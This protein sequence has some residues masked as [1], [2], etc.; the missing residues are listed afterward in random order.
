MI[1]EE[2]GVMVASHQSWVDFGIEK[3]AYDLRW[4]TEPGWVTMEVEAPTLCMVPMEIGG[5]CE[6]RALPDQ[7]VEGEYFGPGALTFAASASR[8]AIH[9]AEI[10]QARLC[11]FV[12]HVS[13]AG[14]LP[15]EATAAIHTLQTRYMFRDERIRTCAGLL[16]SDHVRAGSSMAFAHSL[17]K[18]LY[19]A[20]IEMGKERR[21]PSKI[22]ALPGPIWSTISRYVRDHLDEPIT[23]E[24]LAGLAEMPAGRF[25]EAFREMTGMSLRQW[26]MDHRV[27]S[28]QRL[29]MDNPNESLAEIASLCGFA[30]QSHFSRA[31]LKVIGLTPTA[32]LHSR[33]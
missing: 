31:F 13:D 25:S 20:L 6:L 11:C 1:L 17:S 3:V 9:A 26:H 22:A 10:R 18:A 15:P 2:R 8:V 32:W 30:D 4:L 14:Y 28:A 24:I 23:V 5:R 29:L 21:Q 7:P 19:A 33:R 12:L 16:D 27:R